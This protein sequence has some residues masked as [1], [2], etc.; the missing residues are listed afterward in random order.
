MGSQS[1][2]I[3]DDEDQIRKILTITLQSNGY[4]VKEASTGKSGL[5]SVAENPP[6]LVLLDLGLPDTSGQEVL[7]HLR[8][9]Y[10]NPIIIIS[11]L[12]GEEE[13][14][15]ALNNGA[16]DFLV[17]PFRTEDLLSRIQSGLKKA[18]QEPNR[19][20]LAFN[21]LTIDFESKSIQKQGNPIKFTSMEYSLLSLLA[22]NEGKILTN[23]YLLKE[24]LGSHEDSDSQFLKALIAGIRKKIEAD[25][26]RPK[27]IITERGMG[28]RFMGN[29]IA[30]K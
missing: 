8:D 3:I 14:T 5:T 15:K 7:K 25:P 24:G 18:S 11:V 9:W 23:Q 4:V 26:D 27:Y 28:Y 6:D 10:S 17:K 2:L 22:R 30:T 21:D 1:I 13:I 16:N 19:P 20:V 29:N 12:D